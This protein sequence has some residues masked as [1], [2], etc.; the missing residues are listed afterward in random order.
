MKTKSHYLAGILFCN[1][2]FLISCDFVDKKNYSTHNKSLEKH[3]IPVEKAI[4]MHH[5]YEML[6]TDLLADTLKDIYKKPD[7]KD[8][9][10]AWFSLEDIKA[11]LAY[12]EAIK[13]ANPEQDVS[14][15]RI[16]F[17]AYSN[18]E[19]TNGSQN[20]YPGQQTFFMIPTVKINNPTTTFN[21][22]NHLPFY[23]ISDEEKG[24]VKG[25]FVVSTDLMHGFE[26]EKRLENFNK[27]P[28]VLKGSFG[29]PAKGGST[30]QYRVS[31]VFNEGELTPPPKAY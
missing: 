4:E 14:G 10:F 17:A 9:K 12:I 29:A 27:Q 26:K 30:C 13:K 25:E 6:R 23:L 8:S 19:E 18:G 28:K 1:L 22:L 16:Y 15:I 24:L 20:S 21:A 5:Q 3:L 7:F 2:L 11:Y 31:T